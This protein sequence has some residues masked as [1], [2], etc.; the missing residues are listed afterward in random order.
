MVT[1]I[2]QRPGGATGLKD[3]TI[4]VP[5]VVR[6]G[7]TVTL[8]CHYDLEGLALYSLQWFLEVTEFYRYLPDGDPPY[9]TFNIDGI[10]VNVSVTLLL[11]SLKLIR[12]RWPVPFQT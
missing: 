12:V 6:S 3:L 7:D 11:L 4:N 8:S 1:H 10:H 2:E 5:S 9:R